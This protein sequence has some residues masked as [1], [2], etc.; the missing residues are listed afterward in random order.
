M[1]TAGYRSFEG[2]WIGGA[3]APVTVT[4]PGYRS[5][6][7]FWLGGASGYA[8]AIIPPAPPSVIVDGGG[9]YV[10]SHQWHDDY[11]RARLLKEDEDIVVIM[12]A[13]YRCL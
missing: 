4:Q 11:E 5:F 10:P 13:I 3:S 12:L 2:V 8:Q 1:A 6:E 7:A 9:S